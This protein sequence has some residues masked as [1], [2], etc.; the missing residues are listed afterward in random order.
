MRRQLIPAI[1]SMVIFTVLLGL[2]YPLVVT[3]VAQV[4][5]K[6]KADGSLVEK[7]GKTVGSSMIAQAFTNDKGNPIKKYFQ[8][9]PS[10]GEL[11]PDLQHRLEP[12]AAEPQAH[13]EVPAGAED[14]QGRQRN[15][16]QEGQPGVRDQRRRF[17][18]L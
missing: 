2:V 7:N 5:F 16:R 13:R 3:G 12:R 6:H 11:R 17:E 15:R 8:E 4:A 9:R 10:A 18:G 1:V 14:R